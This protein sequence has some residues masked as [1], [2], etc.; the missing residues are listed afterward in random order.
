MNPFNRMLCSAAAAGL[1]L[2]VGQTV[3]AAEYDVG[4]GRAYATPSDV[5]WESLAPGDTVSIYWQSTPYKDKWVIGRSGTA[6]QPITVRG[7]PGPGGELPVI[8]G[9]GARTR[10]ELDYWNESRGV[11]KI[12]GSSIP[13]DTKPAY[14]VIENLDVR[15]ARQGN[16]FIDAAG[17]TGQY[18]ANAA[19]I[20]IEKGEQIVLRHNRIHDSGNGLFIGSPSLSATRQVLVEANDIFDNGNLNSAYEHNVYT[21]AL[22]ITFQFN[23]LGRLKAGAGGNNLK[24]RSAGLVVRYNWIEGGNRQLDLVDSS[25]AEISGSSTYHETFVYGNV[26]IEADAEGNRQIAMYGGD[27]GDT[28]VFR[29]GTLYFYNNT[30]VSYRPDRTT[31]FGIPTNDEHVD[32]RNNIFYVLADGSTLSIVDEAGIVDLW[33]NW[34]KPGYVSCFS[35]LTGVVTG[36]A[37][38]ILGTSP[39]FVDEAGQDFRIAD[40]S[41]ARDAGTVLAPAA[42][43]SNPL[44]LQYVKHLGSEPRPVDA[45]IDAGAYEAGSGTTQPPPSTSPLTITTTALPGGSSGQAYS[46]TL[47]ASGGAAPYAWSITSGR[48]PAGL[49]LDA[50]SGT[51]A[52][53]PTETGSFPLTIEVSDT[54]MTTASATFSLTISGGSDPGTSPSP[55][56]IVTSQLPDALR[57]KTYGLALEGSGG[58]QP[59]TWAVVAGTLPQNFSL[60]S[61]GILSGRSPKLG[62]YEFTVELRDA[63]SATAQK[64]FSIKVVR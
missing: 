36:Q 18:E 52:G 10:L 1:V 49:T 39:G 55:V 27:S 37:S 61:T 28:S 34:F 54:A 43:G 17:G 63:A 30:V 33:N 42:S 32:A 6:S 53:T 46:A 9:N 40:S 24:D 31:L 23:H 14:I 60:S 59:Y 19:A 41:S 47:Q 25:V 11:I 35:T 44:T 22:G 29:K 4:P 26:L 58:T 51:I 45:A 13:A 64:T 50:A 8:D 7:V 21:E 12:G 3:D 2:L 56:A 5:P 38:S 16:T 62:T 15:G 57:N 48:L 20:Y